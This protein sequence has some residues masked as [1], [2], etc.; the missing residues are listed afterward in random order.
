MDKIADIAGGIIIVA[1]VTTVVSHKQS[2]R[3][4]TALGNT[5]S[6]ALRAAMGK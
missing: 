1:L 4:I 2:A 5:F 3:V 6:G